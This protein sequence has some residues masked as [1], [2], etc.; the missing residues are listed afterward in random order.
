MHNTT[1]YTSQGMY[2][3]EFSVKCTCYFIK[4]FEN[5]KSTVTINESCYVQHG[6]YTI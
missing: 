5:S 3:Y 2:I 6:E 4:C 1:Q